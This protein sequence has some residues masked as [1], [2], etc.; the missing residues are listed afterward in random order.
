[1][2]GGTGTPVSGVVAT[3][4]FTT[5][6]KVALFVQNMINHNPDFTKLTTVSKDTIDQFIEWVDSAIL[7]H[8]SQAGWKVPFEAVGVWPSHQ[9]TYVEL[10]STLGVVSMLKPATKPAPGLG[11]G[12]EGS[13]GNIFD[14]LY[15]TEL[16]KI[17]SNGTT[18][19]HFTAAY[20]R[21]TPAEYISTEPMAPLSNAYL[22]NL[23]PHKT[24]SFTDYV[25]FL[26]NCREGL[27]RYGL[28]SSWEDLKLTVGFEYAY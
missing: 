3:S 24:A 25:N 6:D 22:N 17:Y 16:E 2:A 9:S 5:S 21:G 10:V 23:D 7:M 12:R 14:N 4:P 26:A 13:A 27:V 11:P 15:K 19:L 1:M 18:K 8:F 20:W 28:Q